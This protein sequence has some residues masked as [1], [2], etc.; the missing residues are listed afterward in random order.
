MTIEKRLVVVEVV[1]LAAIAMS[2]V[3]VGLQM[4][5]TQEIA[6]ATMRLELTTA[7]Q[8]L[9]FA[10]AD[11]T[12]DWMVASGVRE[13]KEDEEKQRARILLR[14]AFRGFENYAYQYQNGF[15]D[16]DQ[17]EGMKRGIEVVMSSAFSR[18]HWREISPEFSPAFRNVMND[19]AAQNE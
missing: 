13:A 1:G 6:R 18:D 15:F 17:W 9:I 3:F 8:E 7:S 5:Q 14:A 2:L 16:Q 19:L 12:G 4:K 11:H 10:L